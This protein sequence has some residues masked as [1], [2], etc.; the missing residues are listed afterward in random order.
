MA[1]ANG[2]REMA[3][4]TGILRT[5]HLDPRCIKQ[6][7]GN[8]LKLI[9]TFEAQPENRAGR[10]VRKPVRQAVRRTLVHLACAARQIG[11]GG[12][13][14]AEAR[15]LIRFAGCC[16]DFSA[17]QRRASQYRGLHNKMVQRIND[18]RARG[19]A[20]ELWLDDNHSLLEVKTPSQL[21]S[22]GKQLRNCIGGPLGGHY[23][24]ALRRGESEFWVMRCHGDGVGMLCIDRES[25]KIEECAGIDNEPVGWG[26]QLLLELQRVLSVA[27]DEMEEFIDS[28][29]FS[30]FAN[31]PSIRPVCV[32]IS[33]RPFRTW[34][35]SGQLIICDDCER[36]S[37]FTLELGHRREFPS[38]QATY[39]S[40]LDSEELLCMVAVSPELATLIV[41]SL[42]RIEA[43]D[44]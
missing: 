18:R 28:G 30:L 42:P 12:A 21:R 38:C 41:Q 8:V 32:N 2:L 4:Y 44:A 15:K 20:R 14:Q 34:R 36:W 9:E 13:S 11:D 5:S 26:R 7:T 10:R 27:G 24:D 39:G 31:Q 40:A 35:S 6:A 43:V 22:V 3:Q 33:N 25:R 23:R 29:A 17:L 19:R 16:D 1:N 37:R